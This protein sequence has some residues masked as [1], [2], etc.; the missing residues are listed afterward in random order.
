MFVVKGDVEMLKMKSFFILISM[1]LCFGLAL[2]LFACGDVVYKVDFIVDGEVY[3]SFETGGNEK[4]VIPESPT[5]EGCIF[6]G[7]YRDADVWEEPFGEDSLIGVTLF[8][9]INLYA[10]WQEE[11][12]EHQHTL[13]EWIIDIQATCKGAG[14]RHKECVECGESLVIESIDKLNEH[15]PMDAVRENEALPTCKA[16]GSYDSV[17]YC[18][19]CDA[20]LSSETVSVAK[21]EEH[22]VVVDGRVEPTLT[23]T[24]LTEGS[25]CS[26]CGK[27]F[28]SQEVIPMLPSKATLTSDTMSVSGTNIS[29]RFLST[30]ESLDFSKNVAISENAPWF[31]SLDEAGVNKL[32]KNSVTLSSGDNI[33]YIHVTNPDK[34]VSVYTVAIHRNH[35]YAVSFYYDTDWLGETVFVEEGA[36]LNVPE[37]PT[38]TGYSFLGWDY[39]LDDPV[40]SNL[41]IYA[42]WSARND[43]AYTV[44]YYLEN[45]DKNGYELVETLD[46]VGTT[47][48]VVTV[49]ELEFEHF[50]FERHKG[51]LS[52]EIDAHGRLVLRAYYKRN[53][54][55]VSSPHGSY[56]GAS[57]YAYNATVSIELLSEHPGY[58]F[59]GWYSGETLLCQTRRFS[60][61]IDKNVEAKF[62]VIP[63]MQ[64]YIFESNVNYCRID[65]IKDKTVTALTIPI[66]VTDISEGA[67]SG[68]SALRELTLPFVG[69]KRALG[70]LSA[71]YPFGYIFGKDAYD[72]AVA[73]T[74]TFYHRYPTSLEDETYYIP[75]GLTSVAV[76]DGDILRGAFSECSGL[77]NVRIGSGVGK[78]GVYAFKNCTALTELSLGSGVRGVD[79]YAFS[80]CTALTELEVPISVDYVGD[81]A[82]SGCSALREISIPFVGHK[83]REESDTNHYTF[84]YI[85]GS[86]SYEGGVKVTQYYTDEDGFLTSDVYYV[87]SSLKSVT[88]ERGDLPAGAF[89]GCNMLENITLPHG[90]TSVEDYAFHQCSALLEIEIEDGVKYIGAHAFS[91][92]ETLAEID[93]PESVERIGEYAFS[94]CTG[95]RFIFI[96]EGVISIGGFAFEDCEMLSEISV[97]GDNTAYKSVD[98]SL[99]TKDGSTLIRYPIGKQDKILIIPSGVV[100]IGG[101]ALHFAKNL[102]H[103][104]IPDSA[105]NI[106]EYAFAHCYSLESL[107][108]PSGVERIE[109]YAFAYCSDI[110]SITL[111]ES[112]ESIGD[113]AFI[114]CYRAVEVIDHSFITS[115]PGAEIGMVTDYAFEIHTGE[116]RISKVDGFV[117]Y[118]YEDVNYLVGY[119]GDKTELVLPKSFM[120]ENYK[121][122]RYAFYQCYDIISIS[123]SEGVSDIGAYAFSVCSSL[124]CV[125]IGT[126]V[127]RIGNFV[128]D[129]CEA[130]SEIKYR[131]SSEEWD[132]VTK[133]L[134]WNHLTIADT[135]GCEV[136]FDY[137]DE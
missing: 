77:E 109:R 88:V 16:E 110:T 65:G 23:Q 100:S 96:P 15:S 126:N 3:S 76:L 83:V 52:G 97:S 26:V 30:V 116:S 29:G 60:F 54:Y 113:H 17:V 86:K 94:G 101:A 79:A 78:I 62:E 82:F 129:S 91:D 58:R 85:F 59:I 66:Y 38:L 103:V 98:G 131:G 27:V 34:S 87:P 49:E 112:L 114:G 89:S 108:I 130:L 41:E 68:C 133:S 12:N 63:E 5:K 32:S 95:I 81:G 35:L 74:Q 14:A 19:V 20:K 132:A 7:W 102:T 56:S 1:L 4:V 47:N 107:V 25:H 117:F 69:A 64:N 70:T 18:S 21:T 31:V 115:E 48:S 43:T 73:T 6:D 90:I 36:R 2:S 104:E 125:I 67:L 51:L 61:N 106:G 55:S 11:E 44:Q 120:E 39:D 45:V 71:Q 37:E 105:V 99:Y 28:D 57:Q 53:T 84:G 93:I 40:F 121:I 42:S 119:T 124:E 24:G 118:S 72:G 122:N 128:F 111:G 135:I 46:L 123:I 134:Y 75:E 80:G 8:S 50:T 92:C 10:K 127:E 137:T 13:G 33:F 9:D 22:T 136:S